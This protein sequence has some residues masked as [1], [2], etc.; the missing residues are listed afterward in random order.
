VPTVIG[1][2]VAEAQAR[3]ADQP[4]QA[5][6]VYRPVQRGEKPG[7]VVSQDPK[8]GTVAAFSVVKLVVGCKTEVLPGSSTPSCKK[9]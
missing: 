4:L 2:K 7:I 9:G 3:L 1:A 6:I 5:S 8:N